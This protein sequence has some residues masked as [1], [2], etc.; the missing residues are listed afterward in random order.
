M[1]SGTKRSIILTPRFYGG[2]KGSLCLR[3][4]IFHWHMKE[5]DF[6]DYHLLLDEQ[7]EQIFAMTGMSRKERTRSAELR[8]APS[9]KYRNSNASRTKNEEP[10]APNEDE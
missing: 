1:T 8:P 3:T 10:V 9:A 5:G 7:A 4:K 2:I 6:R